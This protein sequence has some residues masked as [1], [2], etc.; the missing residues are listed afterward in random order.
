MAG[1]AT[2]KNSEGN[3]ISV[4]FV[5]YVQSNLKAQR[6]AAS[7]LQRDSPAPRC[8]FH[9]PWGW[10]WNAALNQKS[11]SFVIFCSLSDIMALQ[12]SLIISCRN[13]TNKPWL[14]LRDQGDF[15]KA[16]FSRSCFTVSAHK[17]SA[18]LL[19]LEMIMCVHL[20][21]EKKIFEAALWSSLNDR[22]TEVLVVG[23]RPAA[24][25]NSRMVTKY[26]LYFFLVCTNCVKAITN[27]RLDKWLQCR[28]CFTA[29]HICSRCVVRRFF[30]CSS[31]KSSSW[32]KRFG[33]NFLEVPARDVYLMLSIQPASALGC[34]CLAL[35][36][37]ANWLH[38]GKFSK[39]ITLSIMVIWVYKHISMLLQL[40]S[41]RH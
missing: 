38:N 12:S 31:V 4:P 15:L 23:K 10:K 1:Y 33:W 40:S 28:E 7:I 35:Y 39:S 8:P 13:W 11:D 36:V 32:G 21:C 27:F 18:I 41:F 29:A 26:I 14:R 22:K 34:S 30:H 37:A 20:T 5:Y 6:R 9:W 3:P 19:R 24:L 16:F 17:W 2:I 25:V